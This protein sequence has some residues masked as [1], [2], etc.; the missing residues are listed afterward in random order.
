MNQFRGGKLSNQQVA[1]PQPDPANF[2]AE[3]STAYVEVLAGVRRPEQ[4]ARWLSERT[5]Y[6]VCQRAAREARQRQLTGL[7][8][9]PDVSLRAS[10][11]FLTDLLAYQGVVVLRIGQTTKAVSIRAEKINARYRITDLSLI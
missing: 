3:I 8:M 11:T 1:V 7:R 6:D 4:L 10:K 9:R 2:F 5:Y